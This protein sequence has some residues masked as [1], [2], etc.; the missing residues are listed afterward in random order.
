MKTG[1]SIGIHC[2]VTDDKL[3]IPD[4]GFEVPMMEDQGYRGEARFQVLAARGTEPAYVICNALVPPEAAAVVTLPLMPVFR[5]ACLQYV[6]QTWDPFGPAWGAPST[7]G[8]SS[9]VV[10]TNQGWRDDPP[11]VAGD[12]YAVLQVI[13]GRRRELKRIYVYPYQGEDNG[14]T[15]GGPPYAFAGI[16]N[17]TVTTPIYISI[18]LWRAD[19][20]SVLDPTASAAVHSFV[21]TMSGMLTPAAIPSG[22]PVDNGVVDSVNWTVAALDYIDVSGTVLEVLFEDGV[23]PGFWYYFKNLTTC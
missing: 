4:A 1:P 20:D 9:P 23:D 14:M 19:Y 5:I 17:R 3:V 16:N 7:S 11:D 12:A 10:A 21:T 22:M 6:S 15:G 8:P 13:N 18:E 2:P